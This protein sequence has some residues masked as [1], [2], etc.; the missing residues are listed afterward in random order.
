MATA[1]STKSPAFQFYPRDFLSSG[2]VDDMSMTERGIYVTFLSRCWLDEGLPVDVSRLAKIARMKPAQF[3]RL[4]NASPL[5]E[6]FYEKGG[7]LQNERLDKERKGQAEFRRKQKAKADKRWESHGIDPAV[8]EVGTRHPSG[9]ALLSA[10]SSASASALK[11]E[12]AE[13]PAASTPKLLTFPTVGH[14]P[15]WDLVEGQ[16]DRWRELYP[17]LDIVS[18]CRKALGWIEQNPTKRKTARGMGSFLVSWL[19]RA[20]DRGGRPAATNG[21]RTAGNVDALQAFIDRGKAS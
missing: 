4:W 16:V 13:P 2:K 17:N 8:P 12:S 3:E 5:R 21:S 10:S 20:V 19:N 1:K 7:K 14:P 18:E 6:C 9:N 15:F 11:K